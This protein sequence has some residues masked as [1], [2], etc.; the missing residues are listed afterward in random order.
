MLQAV[1]YDGNN[2]EEVIRFTGKSEHYKKYFSSWDQYVSYVRSHGNTVKLWNKDGSHLV[3]KP[4][5]WIVRL[6]EGTYHP[7]LTIPANAT[8]EYEKKAKK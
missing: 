4:G 1:Y 6:P 3:V 8:V 7:V 2:L 5:S